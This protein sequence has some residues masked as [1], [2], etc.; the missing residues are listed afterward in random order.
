MFLCK[1]CALGKCKYG[2]RCRF[3][4]VRHQ[5]GRNYKNELTLG[6]NLK[7]SIHA[8]RYQTDSSRRDRYHD[9]K[10]SDFKRP[11]D[12]S[13]D[14]R[15]S[16]KRNEYSSIISLMQRYKKERQEIFELKSEAW[17]SS[18]S[19]L[20]KSKGKKSKKHRKVKSKKSKKE[21]NKSS[22]NSASGLSTNEEETLVWEEKFVQV[23]KTK[24]STVS[25]P[26]RHINVTKENESDSSN[27]D[28]VI[29]P[30]P[31]SDSDNKQINFGHA[32]LPGEGAAMAAYVQDGKRIPRRGEIG[33][34]SEEIV[35]YEDQGYVMSGSQHR[36]ME[37]VRLR[38]ENQIY[39]ADEKRVLAYFNKIERDKKEERI[40][41]HFKSLIEA[42]QKE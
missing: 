11:R 10:D 31:P 20:K 36:R 26:H 13:F 8:S 35:S 15:Q 6:K 24:N 12:Y 38:K 41:D 14:S 28:V 39:S 22:S 23:Q 3:E 4:H 40:R 7:M 19:R 18:P 29:G 42:K 34:T 25:S 9:R 33:L 30:L 5:G 37:A 1:F 32:L 27:E 21:K 17:E 2:D 16:S